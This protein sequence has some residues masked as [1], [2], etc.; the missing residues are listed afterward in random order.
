MTS[1]K[2]SDDLSI[3]CDRD[4][5]RRQPELTKN[6]NIKGNYHVRIMLK[7]IFGFVE[8][9]EKTT[10]GLGYKL[11]ITRNVDNAVLN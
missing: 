7:D 9:Q 1:V 2:D 11:I 4:R 3:G 6:K 10:Y 5:N 8:Y